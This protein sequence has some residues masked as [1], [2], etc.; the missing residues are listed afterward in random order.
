MVLAVRL[1]CKTKVPITQPKR[2]QPKRQSKRAAAVKA[3]T[4]PKARKAF[5]LFVM[6]KAENKAGAPKAT[7]QTE[8]KRLG[9]AWAAL[10]ANEKAEYHAKSAAE[11]EAQRAALLSLGIVTRGPR[12]LPTKDPTEDRP[13]ADAAKVRTVALGP[14]KV[15]ME[16]KDDVPV[17]GSGSYGKV[18]LATGSNGRN[19]AVKVFGG[20]RAHVEASFEI[21][22]YEKK[23]EK[24]AHSQR[25]WSPSLCQSDKK[26]QPWPYLAMS[27]GG[28]SLLEHLRMNGPLKSQLAHSLAVQLQ[29]ALQ[30]LHK[31]AGLLHLDVKPGN[32]LWCDE[33]ASL[34]L[35]D[36]GM[37]EPNPCAYRQSAARTLPLPR[38]MEYVTTWYRAPELWDAKG[39]AASLQALLTPAIDMWSYGCVVFEAFCGQALM[40]AL[41]HRRSLKNTLAE[42]CKGYPELVARKMLRSQYSSSIIAHWAVNLQTCSSL[43]AVVLC[44]CAPNAKSRT[45]T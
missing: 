29:T 33:L 24:L 25:H 12:M 8:M 9:Q 41:D 23:L 5:A 28:K 37:V 16:H 32:I 36:F 45:W 22:I 42:W 3:G 15:N 7:F 31:T 39:Q 26:G 40:K 43:K 34:Q 30:V 35:C 21:G 6:N 44:A 17:L 4:V 20:Y 27:F 18:F 10:P 1:R 14:Y 38:F 13:A 19:C 11:F 2:N